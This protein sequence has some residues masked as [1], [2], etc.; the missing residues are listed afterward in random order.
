MTTVLTEQGGR[1]TLTS[2]ILY[3][4]REARDVVLKTPM[5]QGMATS[6]DRLETVLASIPVDG[7]GQGA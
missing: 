1:T 7:D 5:T 6:Y 3:A 2:T 4:S